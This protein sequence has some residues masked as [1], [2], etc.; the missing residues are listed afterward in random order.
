[1]HICHK[2]DYETEA[3]L[4]KIGASWFEFWLPRRLAC[5]IVPRF[6]NP[7]RG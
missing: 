3:P 5:L 6:V 2:S 7:P 1:M 4:S